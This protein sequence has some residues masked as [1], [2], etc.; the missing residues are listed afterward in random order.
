MHTDSSCSRYYDKKLQARDIKKLSHVYLHPQG[1]S[2]VKYVLS[3]NYSSKNDFPLISIL[4]C[5]YYP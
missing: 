1:T 5:N 4:L 2:R 3:N